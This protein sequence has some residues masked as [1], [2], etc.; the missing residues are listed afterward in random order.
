MK[1]NKLDLKQIDKED[2]NSVSSDSDSFTEDKNDDLKKQNFRI[3]SQRS[4][5]HNNNPE[6][7]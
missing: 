6:H 7:L 3:I 2:S 1:V 5:S 4:S